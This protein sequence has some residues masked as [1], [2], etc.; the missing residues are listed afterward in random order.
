MYQTKAK[1]LL[2]VLGIQACFLP[3]KTQASE[4]FFYWAEKAE[5]SFDPDAKIK[6]YT[7]A[8]EN[9]KPSD[10]RG[11]KATVHYNRELAYYEKGQYNLAIKDY[12]RA[13]KIKQRRGV[14]RYREA[15][16]LALARR[17]KSKLPG[18]A[19]QE[20]WKLLVGLSLTAIGTYMVVDAYKISNYIKDIEE[21]SEEL[22]I[23]LSES[24]SWSWGKHRCVMEGIVGVISVGAGLFSVIDYF[25][26]PKQYLSARGI[27][28]KLAGNYDGV[29]FLISKRL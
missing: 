14:E 17:S 3:G 4:D 8:I 16:K 20:A 11:N 25:T 29:M 24:E 10:G 28:L 7:K 9:W 26:N 22:G 15:L 1:I 2:V 18:Y 27:E 23:D 12:R 13:I 5:V 19:R 6:C 21:E